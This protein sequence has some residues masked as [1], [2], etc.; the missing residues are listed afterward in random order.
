MTVGK[1]HAGETWIDVLGSVKN[2]V[3]INSEGEGDFPV[4]AKN[5]TAF[6]KKGAWDKV[7]IADWSFS[8]YD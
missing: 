4:P 3:E 8:I 7:P 2:L 6:V 1:Q 5:A